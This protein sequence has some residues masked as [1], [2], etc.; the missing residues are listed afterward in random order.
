MFLLLFVIGIIFIIKFTVDFFKVLQIIQI[1]LSLM[2]GAAESSC[3]KRAFQTLGCRSP[4][5]VLKTVEAIEELIGD[6]PDELVGDVQ[7]AVNEVFLHRLGG[8]VA[9]GMRSE[10]YRIPTFCRI[11]TGYR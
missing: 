11:C 10:G 7:A 8:Q 9:L 4:S 2:S 1:L 5:K 3:G 6:I